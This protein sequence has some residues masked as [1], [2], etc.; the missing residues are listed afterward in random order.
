[1]SGRPGV[2]ESASLNQNSL[3]SKGLLRDPLKEAQPRLPTTPW[4]SVAWLWALHLSA[5][6]V[7]VRHWLGINTRVRSP[8]YKTLARDS[9]SLSL[10][11]HL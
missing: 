1:M 4:A 7:A 8:A 9:I 6:R 2:L 11:P 10:F 3:G 5:G